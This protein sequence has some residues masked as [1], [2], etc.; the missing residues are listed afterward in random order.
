MALPTIASLW[1]GEELSWLDQL[2]LQSFVDHG[3]EVVL[4]SYNKVKGVP[5]GV[6]TAEAAE[7]LP[8]DKIIRHARTGSPA[9]HAD[10]FRLHMLQQTDY[11]WADTDAFCC[12]PWDVKKNGH[13]HGWISDKKPL[14]NN[15]V[16]RLPKTSKT[17]KG[18]LKFTEDEYPVPPWFNA[19]RR[20]GLQAL[21]D[22]GKGLH[23]SQMPWGVWGPNALTW[24]L[25]DTG[26]IEHSK[27]GHVIYPV[28]FAIAGVTLNPNRL[29]KARGLIKD[30]TL[31]IHF[32]GR[33]FR[34]I[35][36]KY[37]GVPAKG[38]YV[39]VLLKRH[40][41]DPQKTAYLMQRTEVI[42]PISDVDF[43]MFDDV[44][45]AN[46]ILQRSEIGEVGQEIR[47]WIDGDDAPIL[48]YAKANR[49]T[50]LLETLEVARRECEFFV[51]ST[52][53]P[54]PASIADI[55]CGY[56]FADL[57]LYRRFESDIILIDIEQSK[58]RHLGFEASGAGNASLDKALKFLS[59]NGVPKQKIKL[60]NPNKDKLEKVG[61][62]DLAISLASC[63]FHYPLATYEA[64]F[65]SQI[66]DGGAVVVDVRKGSGGI[67]Y[68][69]QFGAVEVLEKHG[70]Y[71]TVLTRM[72]A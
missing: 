26:E 36:T 17:L 66:N 52:D 29:E 33:R 44:D 11:I 55:G 51:E 30:D 58:E 24:F 68:L 22:E 38:C 7:I 23:V 50:V 34:N 35:A 70:K 28:P 57:F 2:C 49:D 59:K 8:T 65:K 71:S 14:V 72:G 56:A 69:K 46:L 4:F 48:K 12:Q 15:G 32:W 40:N 9:Y 16:L 63:G 18:M 21:K 64:F 41:I 31:S 19:D 3:H 62:V 54:K 61:K 13:F 67:G 42:E 6:K 45:V 39:D 10:V 60:I 53:D 27:P 25:K 1:I 5:K 43:S 37:S 47:D 20:A